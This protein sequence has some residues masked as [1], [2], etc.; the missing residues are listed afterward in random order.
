MAVID[1]DHRFRLMMKIWSGNYRGEQPF[2]SAPQKNL[3][4]VLT[5]VKQI[6]ANAA[7]H[8][9]VRSYVIHEQIGGTD[10]HPVWAT[11]D[12]TDWS[13]L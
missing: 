3:A 11:L 1:P 9:Q 7:L 4:E 10:P 8:S 12:Y 13:D 5:L 2:Y 6:Q